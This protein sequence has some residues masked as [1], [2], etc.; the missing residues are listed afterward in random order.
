M[1]YISVHSQLYDNLAKEYEEKVNSRK[2][3]NRSLVLRFT[4]FIKTGKKVLDVGCA[5]GLDT[6]IFI[7]N[8]FTVTGIDL[9]K[10]MVKFA[11]ARNP[12]AVVIRGDFLKTNFDGT[13]DAIFAQSF[14]HLFPKADAMEVLKKM[15]TLLKPN[16]VV[17]IGTSKSNESREDW[18][19]KTDYSG[20][21]K[22][23]KKYW[24][25]DELR[26]VLLDSGFK[27]LDYFEIDDILYDSRNPLDKVRMV[28]IVKN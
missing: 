22:R 13:F 14:I 12:A 2:E 17:Y 10:E 24:T 27:V 15:K 7:S 11:K 20:N 8:G 5:V 4:K 28:F 9:S 3:Y 6:S 25:K 26:Q 21:H 16:G 18:F 1:N 23:F 19:E